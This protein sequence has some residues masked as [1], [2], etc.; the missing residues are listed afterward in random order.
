[1]EGKRDVSG[2]KGIPFGESLKMFCLDKSEGFSGNSFSQAGLRCF[3]VV[4]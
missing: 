4:L 1:M 2:V 3:A